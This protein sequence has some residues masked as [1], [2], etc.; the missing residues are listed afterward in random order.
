MLH[1][2]SVLRWKTQLLLVVTSCF[3]LINYH[4][5]SQSR[6][7]SK[8]LCTYYIFFQFLCI[9]HTQKSKVTSTVL[10]ISVQSLIKQLPLPLPPPYLLML[11][12]SSLDHF[13]LLD[14]DGWLQPHGGD[15]TV[16]K[17]S[18]YSTKWWRWLDISDDSQQL[19]NW[20]VSLW[21]PHN[22]SGAKWLL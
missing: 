22:G 7:S 11:N 18:S 19:R 1:W 21:F 17:N 20:T 13:Y 9:L 2:Q 14:T 15:R 10:E 6:S 8:V 5:Y 3:F 16:W 12:S 4:I